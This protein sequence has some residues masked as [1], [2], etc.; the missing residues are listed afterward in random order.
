[1]G[2]ACGMFGMKKKFRW[3]YPKGENRLEYLSV[4]GRIILKMDF[5]K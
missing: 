4:D 2:R 5:K 3:R 1:M